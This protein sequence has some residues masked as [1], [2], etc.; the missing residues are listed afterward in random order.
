MSQLSRASVL[1]LSLLLAPGLAAASPAAAANRPAAEASAA[2]Q[3]LRELYTAEWE[4]RQREYG[5]EYVEGRWQP[6]SRLPAVAPR[7]WERRVAYW[8]Q[9]LRRLDA[10]PAAALPPEERINA[11]VFRAMVEADLN[12]ARWRTWEAP[13]NSDS[14][15]WAEIVPWAPYRSEAEWRRFI[16]RLRD[17][18]RYFADQRANMEAGL[19]RGWSVPR[20]SLDGRDRTIEPYTRTGA[21]N[22]ALDVFDAIPASVPEEVRRALREEGRK[23]VLEQVVPAYAGLLDYF[24]NQYLPRT[25]T[26]V[27][28][29]DL[30]GGAEFYRSQ[31]REYVTLDMTPE[32]VHQL[33]LAEVERI[34]AEMRQVMARAGFQGSFAEFLQFLRTD[35]RFYARTPRELLAAASYHAKRIDG[36]LNHVIGTLPRY[37]FTIRPVPDDIAPNY[38]SGRGGLESCLFNTWDLPSRPLYNLPAL[39]LHECAPGHSLQAAL[40]LEAPARP[41]FRQQVYFSGY[42]E[43]WGLYTEWLGTQMGIYETPYEEFGRLTFEMWRAARL[44]IDTGLHEYGWSRQQ[45]ID[46]LASHTA[47][48]QIDVVNEVDRYVSWPGQALSYYI[49]YRTL[50]DLRREAE[51]E[52]GDRFDQKAF[53]DKVLGLGAVPLSTLEREVRGFIAEGGRRPGAATPGG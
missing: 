35:P 51:H 38:T 46:Y 34:S 45:A 5:Y 16:Q 19:A 48:A 3:A 42:G 41:E 26:T 32:Q 8:E 30:P 31:I 2:A 24:R 17:V 50:L 23:V 18:P 37:R 33:G 21:G 12:N 43:G 13:F 27:S 29:R 6:G 39:V 40:A 28:A 4:W 15:F 11:E 1:A 10:I 25:R 47:L 14:F 9:V 20:A 53:H 44:V 7:D 52:L 49:G 22:P 36:E